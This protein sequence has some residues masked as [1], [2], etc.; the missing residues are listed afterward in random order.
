MPQSLASVYLHVVFSTKNRAPLITPDLARRLHPYLA[1]IALG[2]GTK[3]LDIGGM[4]DHVHLLLSFGREVTIAETVKKLKGSSSRWVHDTFPGH[5]AFAWQNGYGA[6]SVGY[7]E[8]GAVRAYIATQEE[9]HREAT[10]QDEYRILLRRHGLEW[11]E[12]YVWD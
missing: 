11:D 10:F 12:R 1:A 7:P 6:F 3:A 9:H 5:R 2:N 8:M 4:P